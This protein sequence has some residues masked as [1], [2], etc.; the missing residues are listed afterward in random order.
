MCGQ[1]RVGFGLD[2]EVDVPAGG[3]RSEPNTKQE[4]AERR[5][6]RGDPVEELHGRKVRGADLFGEPHGQDPVAARRG[7]GGVGEDLAEVAVIGEAV[8]VL[9]DDAHVSF[10]SL[11]RAKMSSAK[12]STFHSVATSS[13]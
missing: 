11:P 1:E 5:P 12:V 7:M 10:A 6:L 13:N 4:H 9:D 2:L 8:L 3:G